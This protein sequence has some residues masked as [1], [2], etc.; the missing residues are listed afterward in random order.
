[1]LQAIRNYIDRPAL[2]APGTSTFWDDAHISMEMLRSHLD[3]EQDGATNN[4]MFVRRSVGWIA[5]AAP[6]QTHPALL[7]LG[8]GPGIYAELFDAAGYTVT[9][10]DFSRRSI[11]YA[12]KSA[13]ATRRPITYRYGDYLMLDYNN[14]FD[15]V[16]MINCDFG[17]LSTENRA[18]LLSKIHAALNAKGLFI[19]DVFTPSKFADFTEGRRWEYALSGFWSAAPYLALNTHYR[20]DEAHTFLR[21][22]IIITDQTAAC[23]NLWDHAFT[24]SELKKDLNH[25]GF[26]IRGVYGDIAGSPAALDGE[27]ICIVAEKRD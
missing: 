22:H 20:Y 19:F 7:D 2:Y 12:Q 14:Q 1:M 25:A 5:E 6:V 9:G 3:P 4:H 10:V 8:C 17:A 27:I 13:R 24:E 15:L 16:T 21:Q 23:T 11:E 26:H 18:N